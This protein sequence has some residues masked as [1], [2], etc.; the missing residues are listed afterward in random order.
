MMGKNIPDLTQYARKT[1]SG[2]LLL[3]EK[4]I[5]ID[6]PT[7]C[8]NCGLCAKNCPMRLMP[9]YIDFYTLAGDYEKAGQYG[10]TACIECGSCA[11]NCPAKRSLV[12]S[13]ALCKA[14]LREKK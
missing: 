9:M 11:Y 6:Q 8:I 5:S 7:N 12:Q 1:D 2:I 14:K 13:I 3:T 10:A 4:E